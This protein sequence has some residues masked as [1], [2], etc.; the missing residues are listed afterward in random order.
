MAGSGHGGNGVRCLEAAS[1]VTTDAATA[2]HPE[3]EMKALPLI[4]A[5]LLAV[6]AVAAC[7]TYSG[8]DP[9]GSSSI[10]R[11]GSSRGMGGGMYRGGY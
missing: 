5:L 3:T 2:C 8:T 9:S 1:S 4:S 7:S 6:M 10:S 11:S